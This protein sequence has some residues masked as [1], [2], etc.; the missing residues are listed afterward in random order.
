[1]EVDYRIQFYLQR[2]QDEQ[3]VRR[4]TIIRAGTGRST[5]INTIKLATTNS[6]KKDNIKVVTTGKSQKE[7]HF[8]CQVDC[9]SNLQH[10]LYPNTVYQDAKLWF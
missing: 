2:P 8:G 1:M 6:V 5:C 3:E 7:H 10:Y 9:I 4:T